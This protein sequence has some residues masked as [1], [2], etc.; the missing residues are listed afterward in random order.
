MQS[1]RGKTLYLHLTNISSQIIR[2]ELYTQLLLALAVDGYRPRL[3]WIQQENQNRPV[4]TFTTKSIEDV[5]KVITTAQVKLDAYR[6]LNAVSVP[7]VYRKPILLTHYCSNW[8]RAVLPERLQ[9]P[10]PTTTRENDVAEA[11]P[12]TRPDPGQEEQ[13]QHHHQTSQDEKTKKKKRKWR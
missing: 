2:T 5:I 8:D 11:G 4:T 12:S 9:R 6:M 3:T 13:H 7:W 10:A 1:D